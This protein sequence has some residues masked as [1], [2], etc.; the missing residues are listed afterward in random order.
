MARKMYSGNKFPEYG[1]G[2]PVEPM[3]K[4][5]VDIAYGDYAKYLNEYGNEAMFSKKEDDT[6]TLIPA[7]SLSGKLMSRK[8]ALNMYRKTYGHF[9]R[10]ASESG[11]E[12]YKSWL[13]GRSKEMSEYFPNE[14]IIEST[15]SK[16]FT[17]SHLL[18]LRQKRAEVRNYLRT[19]LG[20]QVKGIG[21]TIRG[22]AERFDPNAIDGDNDGVVQDGTMWARP[23]LPGAPSISS[24]RSISGSSKRTSQTS[25]AAAEGLTKKIKKSEPKITSSLKDIESV[26]DGKVSLVD[27]DKRFKD[28]DSLAAKIERLKGNWDNDTA[29]AASQMNDALRYTFVVNKDGDYT[30]FVKSTFAHLQGSGFGVTS[31]NYWGSNDPYSGVNAMIEHPDGFNF[32]IQFHTK[33][34]LAAKKKM[35]PLYQKFKSE[36]DSSKRKEIYDRMKSASSG[37]D[38]PERVGEIGEPL[39]R[40]HTVGTFT[41]EM[42]LMSSRSSRE[43]V[44]EQPGVLK[45][46]FPVQEGL[47][48]SPREKRKLEAVSEKWTEAFLAMATG[49]YPL[50]YDGPRYEYKQDGKTIRR[51]IKKYTGAK[52]TEAEKSSVTDDEVVDEAIALVLAHVKFMKS[53]NDYSFLNYVPAGHPGS[54]L[55]KDLAWWNGVL[56]EQGLQPVEGIMPHP[57]AVTTKKGPDGQNLGPVSINGTMGEVMKRAG[58]G[59]TGHLIKVKRKQETG[60]SDWD[61]EWREAGYGGTI[62]LDRLN[63]DQDGRAFETVAGEGDVESAIFGMEGEY[64]PRE[65]GVGDAATEVDVPDG[66]SDSTRTAK[67]RKMTTEEIIR[68]MDERIKSTFGEDLSTSGDE[69]GPLSQLNDI[70]PTAVEMFIDRV[71]RELS[72]EEFEEKHSANSTVKLLDALY[73]PVGSKS[74]LGRIISQRNG[75]LYDM[76]PMEILSKIE[77]MKKDIMNGMSQSE[78]RKK[79]S[80]TAA[81]LELLWKDI[82]KGIGTIK[83]RKLGDTQM[84]RLSEMLKGLSEGSKKR[85][86]Y[87]A[88]FD[89]LGVDFTVTNAN[90]GN[91]KSKLKTLL[92]LGSPSEVEAKLV[93]LGA[94]FFGGKDAED[95]TELF[96]DEIEMPSTIERTILSKRLSPSGRGFSGR[97]FI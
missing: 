69:P 89:F 27:L 12:E 2:A 25:R 47:E 23:A 62:S 59:V 28:V 95:E 7:V 39:K 43:G 91:A 78:L 44:V 61:E 6:F 66:I 63:E 34:S 10:F 64:L 3:E 9:G 42:T 92:G 31:W 40:G 49:D 83:S 21:R 85:D 68:T 17:D 48:L 79:Y 82:A 35:E 55:E 84:E 72:R 29:A 60:K 86:V 16:L 75:E 76:G 14:D 45:S 90:F 71:A 37:I 30:D 13:L 5:N 53:K 1:D 65:G 11:L 81:G 26:S 73:G 15:N 4:G 8:K 58:N 36:S 88:V 94:V 77:Q 20:I 19:S 24:M 46:L 38:T 33:K 97:I 52:A 93:E 56:S 50:R 87:Q 41:P 51:G 96:D 74:G 70:V 54:D 22:V 32:E 80:L 67:I 18:G 57:S